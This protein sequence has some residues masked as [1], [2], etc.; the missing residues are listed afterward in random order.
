[1]EAKRIRRQ[2]EDEVRR[3]EQE[4]RIRKKNEQ[5]KMRMNKMQSY[6]GSSRAVQ[7]MNMRASPV[8]RNKGDSRRSAA[9]RLLPRKS[10]DFKDMSFTSKNLLNV[11]ERIRTQVEEFK[12]EIEIQEPLSSSRWLDDP[13]RMRRY[14]PP[15][16]FFVNRTI[17]DSDSSED[18]SSVTN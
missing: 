7:L 17:S 10:V 2:K 3:S 9:A 18:E 16:N 12:D 1:M 4:K 6:V 11:R 5:M 8:K 13:E 15:V 14:A